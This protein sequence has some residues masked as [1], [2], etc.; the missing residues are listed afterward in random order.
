MLAPAI[1]Y[2]IGLVGFPFLLSIYYSVLRDRRQQRNSLRRAAEFPANSENLNLLDL[3]VEHDRLHGHHAGRRP[4]FRDCA[5]PGAAVEF[6]RQMVGAVVDP[7][8]GRTDFAR[9]HRLA[10]DVRFDLQRDQWTLRAAG[11]LQPYRVTRN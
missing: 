4:R 8:V 1:L 2:I 3:A 9:Q 6:S 10:V 11:L 7:A 5:G